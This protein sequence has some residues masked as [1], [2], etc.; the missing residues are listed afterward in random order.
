MIQIFIFGFFF[1]FIF[2]ACSDELRYSLF[3]SWADFVSNRNQTVDCNVNWNNFR[4]KWAIAQHCSNNAFGATNHNSDW[5]IQTVDPSFT[6][7]FPCRWNCS[8]KEIKMN[9][10][11]KTFLKFSKSIENWSIDRA[12]H[13]QQNSTRNISFL[14][15][16]NQNKIEKIGKIISIITFIRNGSENVAVG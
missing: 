14:I 5:S 8:M 11:Q 1:K 15:E 16:Q 4:T 13:V 9:R 10:N 12:D 3:N 2:L 6:W 7:L